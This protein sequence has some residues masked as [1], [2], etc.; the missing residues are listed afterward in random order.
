MWRPA[1]PRTRWQ[2]W[3]SKF[4]D[5]IEVVFANNDAMAL[6]AINALKAAGYFKG[7]KYM[8]VVGVDAI[9]A[10]PRRHRAGHAP[11]YRP[12]RRRQAGPGH[13]RSGLR[14]RPGQGR[15]HRCRP[16]SRTRTAPP[17]AKGQYIWVPYVKVTKDN[18]TQFKK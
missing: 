8:P 15:G 13:L 6:G 11:R 9:P 12:Q 3:L 4:G 5:K 10:G 7:E 14:P 18:Y 2:A 16:R 17:I 1:T